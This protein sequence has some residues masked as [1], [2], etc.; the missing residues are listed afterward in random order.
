MISQA[1]ATET[2]NNIPSPLGVGGLWLPALIVFLVLF[3]FLIRPKQKK[4]N[5]KFTDIRN[6][7]RGDAIITTSG[8]YC[9]IKKMPTHDT[10]VVEIAKGVEI[11]MKKIKIAEVL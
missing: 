4:L 2:A 10:M 8:I 6:V 7:K 9:K 5:K 11:K 1:F 3:F